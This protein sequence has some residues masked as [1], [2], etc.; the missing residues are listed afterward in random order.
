[1]PLIHQMAVFFEHQYFWKEWIDTLNIFHEDNHQ[2]NVA[3][4]VFWLGLANCVYGSITLQDFLNIYISGKNQLILNFF[5]RERIIKLRWY[6]RL[7]ILDVYSQ[8]C[9]LSN[10]I[11]SL[12]ISLIFMHGDNHNGEVRLPLWFD[13]S[14]FTSSLIRF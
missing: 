11:I 10:Y 2:G 9:H 8:F 5:Y 6:M 1:M 7:P 14:S 3:S 12:S 13:V 4:W